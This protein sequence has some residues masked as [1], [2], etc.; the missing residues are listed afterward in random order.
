M[1]LIHSNSVMMTP[2]KTALDY[3]IAHPPGGGLAWEGYTATGT[4]RWR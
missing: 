3:I 1:Y 2:T 4:D